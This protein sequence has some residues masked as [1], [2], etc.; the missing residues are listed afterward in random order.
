MINLSEAAQ[1]IV[2]A[3]QDNWKYLLFAQVLLEN[4]NRSL[5]C[6]QL[7][8]DNRFFSFG[9]PIGGITSKNFYEALSSELS[10]LSAS[11]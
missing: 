10:N 1:A 9:M 6:R 3:K 7:C 4:A 5:S 2:A 8:E 11:S